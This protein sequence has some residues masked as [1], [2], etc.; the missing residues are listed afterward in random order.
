[1]DKGGFG[2]REC[3]SSCPD[4]ESAARVLREI[5]ISQVDSVQFFGRHEKYFTD[6]KS[7]V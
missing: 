7:V 6:R 4:S 3:G 1:M 2:A 5:E